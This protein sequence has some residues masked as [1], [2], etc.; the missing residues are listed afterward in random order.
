MKR[1][2]SNMGAG[3]SVESS[4][5]PLPPL[6]DI[7]PTPFKKLPEAIEEALFV[8]EKF[9]L[10]IDPTEQ[11]SRF[12]KY[13]AGTFALSDD[14]VQSSVSRLNRS[15]VSCLLKG[16]TL[17]WKFSTLGAL[18]EN[19]FDSKLFPKEILSRS[20]FYKDEVWKRVLHRELGDPDPNEV[21][22]SQEFAFVICVIDLFVP[23][24]LRELMHVI[25]IND[26][27]ATS[28][29][30]STSAED[31]GLE[32]VAA[33][34][35]ATEVVRN[36]TQL[37]EAAFDGELDEVKNWIEKGYHIESCD[38]RKHTA[39]SEASCQGQLHVV[40]YLL[41]QG[42][43]PN[44]LS[45]TNRSPLWRAAFSGHVHVV[46]HL[47]HAG[48]DPDVRDKVSMESAFDVAQTDDLRKIIVRTL[49]SMFISHDDFE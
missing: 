23:P 36:S 26:G 31:D 19:T 2:L 25:Y 49:L 48:G 41:E 42:A 38:G 27:A 14:P 3:G 17:T 16:G 5:A 34:F 30:Q 37:V 4:K 11:A 24:Q 12:L 10:I 28:V 20:V 44:A 13:Q 32:Q 35:G 43:N 22:P 1:F 40:E 45:D 9:P 46:E 47:L 29:D 18:T 7:K 33:L 21:D 15:L 39:L 8:H 6:E